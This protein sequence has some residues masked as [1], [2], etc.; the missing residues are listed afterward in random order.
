[1]MTALKYADR[2]SDPLLVH[3][4]PPAY[5]R[6]TIDLFPSNFATKREEWPTNM[7]NMLTQAAGSS[8][9]GK[10]DLVRGYCQT[11][12][13]EE[14]AHIHTFGGADSNSLYK[15]PRALQGF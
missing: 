6:V 10:A 5:F 4:A 3:K 7:E 8:S 2:I 13:D 1:M 12:L 15:P 14:D 9:Y 11:A